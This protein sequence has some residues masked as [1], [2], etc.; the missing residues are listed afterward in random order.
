[1]TKVAGTYGQRRVPTNGTSD[2][3]K[4]LGLSP[5]TGVY[6]ATVKRNDDPQYMGRLKVWIKQFGGSDPESESGWISV[7]YASPFAGST[8][9]FDQG[10]NVE[11]YEDTMK[12]YGL[13]VPQPDIDSEVLVAFAGG[14]LDLGFWFACLYNRG[15]QI[16]VPGIPAKTTYDGENI[17]AA[18]KNKKDQDPNLDK[19][20]THKPLWNALKLQGLDKDTLRGLTT[21]SAMRETPSRVYGVLTPGQHQFIMDDGDKEGVFATDHVTESAKKDRAKRANDEASGEREQGKN[22]RRAL[23]QATEKLLGNDRGQ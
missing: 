21:S 15:T 23:I 18:P 6:I 5:A 22:E 11:K 2:D 12:P 19:F 14:R 17:P 4:G 10:N 7:S 20:V 9:V 3:T 8:S 1:M 16:T 13:W